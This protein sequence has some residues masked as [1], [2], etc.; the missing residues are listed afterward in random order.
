M[1]ASPDQ[2]EYLA[3]T[4]ADLYADVERR[5]LELCARQ[6]AVGQEAPG[7][8]VAKLA[9]V[10]PLRRASDMLVDTLARGVDQEVRH[11]VAD[12]YE[13]GR[14]PALAELGVLGDD[15]RRTVAE[16]TPQAQAVDRL[17]A[18]TIETVTA[19]H[20]GAGRGRGCPG[21]R[22]PV[23]HEQRVLPVEAGPEQ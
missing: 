15:D 22:A 7:W 19:T 13:S 12:A 21:C 6:L 20:P 2:V 18:E 8:A 16:R 17:A 1:S 14:H 3:A 4:T 9:A 5:L 10:A 23:R 11:V